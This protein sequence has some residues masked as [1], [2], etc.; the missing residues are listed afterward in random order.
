MRWIYVAG[1]A[2]VAATLVAEVWCEIDYRIAAS[3]SLI[4]IAALALVFAARYAGW[5]K[6]WS[7]R[8]GKVYL[9]ASVILALV[10]TQAAIAS[11]W[12][13]DYPG[14]QVIRFVIYSLGAITYVP[15]LVSLRRE[16]KRDRH[17]RD[18]GE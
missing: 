3:V 17:A 10:L 18:V 5:S 8:I 4:Y 14:R 11:W 12:N 13:L 16:Q 1:A 15:M 9:A 2:A 6:W 7:K